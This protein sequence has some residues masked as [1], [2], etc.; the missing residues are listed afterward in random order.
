MTLKFH[1]Y[2][3]NLLLILSVCAQK[4]QA[5]NASASKTELCKL[6]IQKAQYHKLHPDQLVKGDLY[7][8]HVN[9]SSDVQKL[10]FVD[11]AKVDNDET[12]LK[13]L[14]VTSLRQRLL[15]PAKPVFLPI[16]DSFIFPA[17]KA[18]PSS[19]SRFKSYLDKSLFS[20]LSELK[21]AFPTG[22][23]VFETDHIVFTSSLRDRSFAKQNKEQISTFAKAI[24]SFDESL[25][26][27][28]WTPPRHT[29]VHFATKNLIPT[30]KVPHAL[31]EPLWSPLTGKNSYRI[32]LSNINYP[33]QVQDSLFDLSIATH[34]RAHTVLA[35]MFSLKSWVMTSPRVNEGICDFLAADATDNPRIGESLWDDGRSLRDIE[36]RITIVNNNGKQ[37]TD[38]A[39]LEPNRVY[40]YSLLY[41]EVL[42]KI[43][44]RTGS[45][46]AKKILLAAIDFANDHWN[47]YSVLGEYYMASPANQR[48]KEFQFFIV[49]LSE[50]ALAV[51]GTHFFDILE[52]SQ[53]SLGLDPHEASRIAPLLRSSRKDWRK[54]A[55]RNLTRNLMFYGKLAIPV[56]TIGAGGAATYLLL[57]DKD[58]KGPESDAKDLLPLSSP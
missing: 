5:S 18:S 45:K 35:S 22:Q 17:E 42:W 54:P 34:E 37:V 10:K 25:K 11:V 46:R 58:E 21:S 26:D 55:H 49:A 30:K 53:V 38:P 27:A 13:F 50:A 57:Q 43:R 47:P 15:S 7:W 31:D 36:N 6:W 41:S 51:P 1:R 29:V 56:I 32:S 2:L 24:E 9:G 33:D 20:F 19:L 8:V 44:Q 39:L 14:P 23:I 52:N 16:D 48:I 4:L 28:G 40:E 12:R 3:L